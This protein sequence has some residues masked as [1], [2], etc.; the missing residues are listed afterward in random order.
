MIKT[1]NNDLYVNNILEY[2]VELE[3]FLINLM[4]GL[5]RSQGIKWI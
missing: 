2:K 4:R 5:Q 3:A 1:S